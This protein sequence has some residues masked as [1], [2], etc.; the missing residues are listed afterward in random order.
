MAHRSNNRTAAA[1]TLIASISVLLLIV[2]GAA[3]ATADPSTDPQ[4]TVPDPEAGSF[5]TVFDFTHDGRVVAFDGFIVYVQQ[6]RQ[7]ATLT[8]IGT[9]PELYRG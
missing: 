4:V 5:F 2:L 6:S 8:P 1:R 3:L 9:L 7:S